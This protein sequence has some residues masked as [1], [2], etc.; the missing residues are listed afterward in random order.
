MA[1]HW[2]SI[3]D[4]YYPRGSKARGILLQHSMQVAVMALEIAREKTLDLDPDDIIAAAM[5]HDVGIV[6]T[7]AP[8]IGCSG[9]LH[10]LCH[11]DAGAALIRAEG[12]EALEP[13][14]LVAERHTGA[15]ITAEEAASQGLPL[16]A[17]CHV[18]CTTLEKLICYADKFYS[19]SRT[20]RRKSLEAARRSIERFGPGAA[21]RFEEMHRMFDITDNRATS[22]TNR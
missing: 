9:T 7:N 14:A 21:E 8:S 22:A 16:S 11:G 20:M 3:I 17:A 10:Y 18:P 1:N 5:L 4:R 15:G 19:K 12:I 13:F 2:Q 6:A